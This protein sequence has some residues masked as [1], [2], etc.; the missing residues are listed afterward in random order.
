[1]LKI[2]GF[3]E[4][5]KNAPVFLEEEGFLERAGDSVYERANGWYTSTFEGAEHPAPD[6]EEDNKKFNSASHPRI[7]LRDSERTFYD[8]EDREKLARFLTRLHLRFQDYSQGMGFVAS[9]LLL[10]LEPEKAE[11]MIRCVNSDPK[12][13]PGYW[14]NEAV[15]FAV[16]AYVF[17]D[18]LSKRRPNL[19]KHLETCFMQPEMYCQK[20]FTALCVHTLPYEFVFDFMDGFFKRGFKFLFQFALS[21]MDAL[22]E[23]LLATSDPGVLLAL[24]RLDNEALGAPLDYANIISSAYDIDVDGVDYKA[25]REEM[26]NK[27]LKPRMERA[28]KAAAEEDSD[29]EIVFSDEEDDE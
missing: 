14:K 29:D 17:G 20:W 6:S 28:A 10:F 1:M 4:R 27:Y 15:G 3:Y 8:P 19:S 22:E 11:E 26:F 9:F 13:I 7:V 23:K 21:L 5:E 2:K 12:F 18:L 24:L 25:L 16:D